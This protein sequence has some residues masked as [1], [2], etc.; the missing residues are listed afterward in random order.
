[1][2]DLFKLIM[3]QPLLDTS[4]RK[5][6]HKGA[7]RLRGEIGI[8]MEGVVSVEV[9]QGTGQQSVVRLVKEREC[10][11]LED[12]EASNLD[13]HKQCVVETTTATIYGISTTKLK[14]ALALLPTPAKAK[15]YEE[16]FKHQA[17]QVHALTEYAMVLNSYDAPSK[18]EW[19]LERLIPLVHRPNTV[20]WDRLSNH[21]GLSP[22]SIHRSLK[23]LK[24]SGRFPAFATKVLR[25]RGVKNG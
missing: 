12:L 14:S 21:T 18:L 1:M 10:I 17:T 3:A 6:P 4:M 7:F 19:A 25:E 22:I 2:D 16:M 11:N 13:L 8:V 5:Y 9:S 23:A 24:T 15:I 20:G